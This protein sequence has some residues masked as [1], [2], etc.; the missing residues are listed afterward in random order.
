MKPNTKKVFM[1]TKNINLDIPVELLKSSEAKN[2][3]KDYIENHLFRYC[4]LNNWVQA[5][6]VKFENNNFLINQNSQV[7]YNIAIKMDLKSVLCNVI[8][9]EESENE[10]KK[11]IEANNLET[12]TNIYIQ[13][14]YDKKIWFDMYYFNQNLSEVKKNSIKE[15]I[16]RAFTKSLK[17]DIIFSSDTI[18]FSFDITETFFSTLQYII[19]IQDMSKLLNLVSINGKKIDFFI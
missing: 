16:R 17:S 9:F 19:Y 14:L 2:D 15:L 4:E 7:Y 1:I 13:K 11:I 3:L 10:L 8:L 18:H 12:F 5:I 6:F